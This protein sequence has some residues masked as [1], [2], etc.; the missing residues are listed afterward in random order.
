[1][2]PK[3]S[4]GKLPVLRPDL[5]VSF[6]HRLQT[7]RHSF[8]SEALG[9]TV[10]TLDI[11]KVDREL[12]AY[13]GRKSLGKMASFGLRGEILFPVPLILRSRPSLLGYNRLLYGLSQKEFYRYAQIA[14]FKRLEE[15]NEIRESL[16]PRLD[17]LCQSLIPRGNSCLKALP[18]SI[19]ALSGIFNS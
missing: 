9:S 16:S 15:S 7:F 3:P 19:S 11:S 18:T 12:A 8:L 1:M 6:Y 14:P 4:T 13:V 10:V 5:Q 17:S 2:K